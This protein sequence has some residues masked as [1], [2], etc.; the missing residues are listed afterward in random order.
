MV[1]GLDADEEKVV[2]K[3]ERIVERH[4]LLFTYLPLMQQLVRYLGRVPM[5]GP[6]RSMLVGQRAVLQVPPRISGP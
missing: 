2:W 6:R 5:H 3:L 4:Q 1:H